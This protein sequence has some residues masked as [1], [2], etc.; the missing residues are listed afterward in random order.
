[1][2]ARNS[3]AGKGSYR[4]VVSSECYRK[5]VSRSTQ[6]EVHVLDYV[7]LDSTSDGRR[8]IFHFR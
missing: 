8:D 3:A 2:F 6:S 5:V 1:M 4:K 7:C